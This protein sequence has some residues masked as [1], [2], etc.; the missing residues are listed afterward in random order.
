[1]GTTA[2]IPTAIGT[3]PAEW[4]ALTV[5]TVGLAAG[6]VAALGDPAFTLAER[7][8]Q[9]IIASAGCSAAPCAA[10]PRDLAGLTARAAR[11]DAGAAAL[12]SVAGTLPD[13]P[14]GARALPPLAAGIVSPTLAF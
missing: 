1:M 5:L 4:A 7:T 3:S 11:I 12:R 8:G 9:A 13:L 10:P 2:F 6:G 14:A